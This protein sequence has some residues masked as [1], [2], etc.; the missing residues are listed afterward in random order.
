M[1]PNPS[2]RLAT[3]LD[4]SSPRRTCPDPAPVFVSLSVTF[5]W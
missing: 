3:S 4:T 2:R 5:W 1:L